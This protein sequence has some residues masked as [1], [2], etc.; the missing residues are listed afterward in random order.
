MKHTSDI[1]ALVR[2]MSTHWRRIAVGVAGLIGVDVLQL[3]VPQIVRRAVDALAAGTA[4]LLGLVWCGLGMCAAAVG[5]GLCR[6]VWRYFLIGASH[7]IE[8]DLRQQLYEHWL[9]LPAAYYDQHKVGDLMSHATNDAYA[10]RRAVGFAAL[11]AIDAAF[12]A[13]T[14]LSIMAWMNLKLTLIVLVP[15]PALA[16]VMLRFGRLMHERFERVQQVFGV[17]TERAQEAFSG[18]RVVK[19]YGAEGTESRLFRAEAQRYAEETVRLARVFAWY[20]PLIGALAS[21]SLA[22]LLWWGGR[23]VLAG[24]LTLGGFVA[25]MSYVGMLIWPMIAVGVV[26]NMMERGAASLGRIRRILETPAVVAEGKHHGGVAPRISCCGLTFTYSGAST[27][28]LVDI[29]CEIPERSTVGIVGRTGSGKTTLLEVLMRVYDPPPG[30]VWLGGVDIRELPLV[31]VRGMFAYVPQEPFLFSLSVA[32]NI[33]F[34]RPDLSLEEVQAL[35]RCVGLDEEVMSFPQGYD[36]VVGERG[37]TLSGG[38]K[39]RVAIARAL[40]LR[41]PILVLDDALSSVDAETEAM[42]LQHL[43]S[44][45]GTATMLIVAHR[46]SALKHA[47]LIFVMDEG[48]IVDCGTHA[49]LISREGY[50]RE[51]YEL[52]RIEAA[53]LARLR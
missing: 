39:Q 14:V 48:R 52:Q 24:V 13:V 43:R 38:Q 8:R 17:L 9:K 11:A 50:Y 21:S 27:P 4:T 33:R 31:T 47:D 35:A 41:A 20:D 30:T 44:L 51:L 7:R 40:A 16:L 28:T 42:I 25:F 19:A 18:I 1:I 37:I 53:E 29:T 46:V 49:E 22:L 45:A 32:D 12:L 5:M 10:V 2:L 15:L 23:S 6:F 34:G 36:T 26:V 3:V